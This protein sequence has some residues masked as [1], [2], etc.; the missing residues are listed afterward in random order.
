[1]QNFKLKANFDEVWDKIEILSTHLLEICDTC[2]K[3][4]TF[5]GFCLAY[6]FTH[7]AAVHSGTGIKTKK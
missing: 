3:L 6:L 1:M 2:Q 4:A 7:N 5:C